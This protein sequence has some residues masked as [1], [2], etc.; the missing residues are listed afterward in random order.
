MKAISLWQPWAT[1]M[2]NNFKTIETRGWKT[3]YRGDLLICS[4]KNGLS[5]KAFNET[6]EHLGMKELE[7]PLGQALCV[8]DLYD[9]IQTDMLSFYDY[10]SEEEFGDYS[11][12]RFAWL[13]DS[14]RPIKP[15]QVVGQQGLF[16]VD[17]ELIEFL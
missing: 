14:C 4:T 3:N 1:L 16:N 6:V 8:V 2:A 7:Y 11:P 12:G 13:T 17:D 10:F 9:V 15:F 5:K